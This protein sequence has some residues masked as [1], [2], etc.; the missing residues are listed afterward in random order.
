MRAS[1][2]EAD[3]RKVAVELENNFDLAMLH[4]GK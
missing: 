2:G 1:L 3:G 4:H